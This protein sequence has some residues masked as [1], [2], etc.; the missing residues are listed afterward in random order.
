MNHNFNKFTKQYQRVLTEAKSLTRRASLTEVTSD[1]L[2]S[3]LLNTQGSIAFEIMHKLG[4]VGLQKSSLIVETNSQSAS[5]SKADI[6]LSSEVK[7]I[8]KEYRGFIKVPFCS[9]EEDGEKCADILKAETEGGD[10]CG[11]LYPKEE[12]LTSNQKC[13]ICNKKAK[14]LVYVAKSY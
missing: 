7:K 13:I 14:H 4:L 9:V 1:H 10:V 8:I 6:T 12:K 2:W 11:T 5:S 3:A